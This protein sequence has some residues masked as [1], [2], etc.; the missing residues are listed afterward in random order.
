[1]SSKEDIAR[2]IK[3]FLPEMVEIRH[4]L[5]AHPELAY[6][7]HRTSG[8]VAELLAKW[9]YEVTKNIGKTGVVGTL[10]VGNS[11]KSIGIRADMDALPMQEETNLAYAS[12]Y[13]GKMHACGHDGHTTTLL[14]AARYLAETKQ[15]DGTL[16][17][18]FQPAEEGGAGAK[19]M[20]DD[21]LF[22]K[23]PCDAVFGLHNMPGIPY[24]HMHC[25][26]GSLMAAADTAHITIEGVGGHG[27]MAHITVDPI[28]AASSVVM[29]L[30]SIVSRNVPAL[31][32]VVITAGMFQSGT[33]DN[34]I[35]NEAKL[36]LTIRTF[37]PQMRDLARERVCALVKAQAQSYG[38]Q[39]HIDYVLGYPCTVNSASQTEF[40]LEIARDL[41]GSDKVDGNTPP[42]TGSE[43]F[44][45]MLEKCPGTYVFFG[46][47][48]DVPNVHNSHYDFHDGLIE[49]GANY[50]A[51]LTQSY[52]KT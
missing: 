18:F 3:S 36:E 42:L 1:M 38:A 32:S 49:V 25:R 19:A 41:L 16:H 46:S 43:D 7:E 4:D 34:I 45:F 5:H 21:G 40:A 35:P 31:D 17:L 28:V 12:R 37:S 8:I 30:Q 11:G 39:A 9:G 33:T 51:L 27:A 15:F 47:G 52:L 23:F 6:E 44:S 48:E 14:A 2:H 22:E 50:W 20:I 29:A 26:P 10:R 13:E 24:G